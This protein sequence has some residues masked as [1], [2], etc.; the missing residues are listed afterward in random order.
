M[1]SD[2]SIG[3][4][5][6][7]AERLRRAVGLGLA[8]V[9]ILSAAARAPGAFDYVLGQH[10]EAAGRTAA[11]RT[12]ATGN[13]LGID[14]AYQSAA[15]SLVPPTATFAVLV[16]SSPAVAERDYGI[17]SLTYVALPRYLLFLLM[18]AREVP[19]RTAQYV[20][21]YGCNTDPWDGR[22]DW[23]YSDL[24]GHAIGRVNGR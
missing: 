18:P 8:I 13:I 1:V 21:C 3:A 4:D 6:G 19:A 17:N 10:R 2:N 23:L 20:L 15:L 5:G 16:S 22:T 24:H 9:A 11:D 14:R 7:R 12:L